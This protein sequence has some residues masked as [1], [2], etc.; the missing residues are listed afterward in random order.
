MKVLR[1]IL[2]IYK[3]NIISSIYLLIIFTI[4][5]I[6]ASLSL[7]QYRYIT[8]TKDLFVQSN[9][10]NSI[11]YM[12]S[13]FSMQITSWSSEEYH[14]ELNKVYDNIL[15]YSAVDSITKRPWTIRVD[16]QVYDEA[17]LNS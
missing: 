6:Y 11:Y 1:L 4:S 2:E 16:I 7:G 10:Q 12:P 14:Y 8:Y 3:K 13:G 9:L 5:I 15:A 17:L